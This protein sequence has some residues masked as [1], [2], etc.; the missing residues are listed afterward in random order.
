MAEIKAAWFED[1]SGDR[2]KETAQ[3]NSTTV[4]MDVYFHAA[5]QEPVFAFHLRN[6]PRHLVFATSSDWRDEPV[7]NF[8]AGET[9]RVKVRFDNWLAPNRYTISPSVAR[10]G[11]GSDIVDLREDL[12]SIVVHAVRHTGGIA[13]VPHTLT[14][15]TA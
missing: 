6:E 4:C 11:T 10:S 3:G 7:G 9:A 14:I 2:I 1:I 8:E 13:D 12:A 5:M 15:T